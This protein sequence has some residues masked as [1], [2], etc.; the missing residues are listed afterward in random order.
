MT[1]RRFVSAALFGVIAVV[2]ACAQPEAA[3]K[4]AATSA[5][6]SS[7]DG[8]HRELVSIATTQGDVRFY[9]E[10]ADTDAERARGLMFRREMARDH[11]ML[12]LFEEP[13]MQSFWMRNTHLSLDLIFIAADG[14]IVNIIEHATP[15]SD[16]PL[17][18][19]APAV[20]V[21]EINAGL[22]REMGV[23]AGDRVQHPRIGAH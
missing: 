13:G 14:R 5:P 18:S 22:S 20:A 8:A 16:A 3:S 19:S 6:V 17:R 4:A 10:I 15:Y 23:A 12:F 1:L 2:G 21:L 7:P 9:A 11:G